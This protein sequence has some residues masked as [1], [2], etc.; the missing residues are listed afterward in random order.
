MSLKLEE[1]KINLKNVHTNLIFFDLNS[2][3]ITSEIFIKELLNYDIK[4]DYK[5]NN[6][7]RMVTHYG[8]EKQHINIV[9][10]TLKKIFQK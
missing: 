2:K 1:I 7:F 3:H 10:K 5:G 6:R 4:I 8:F 9:I